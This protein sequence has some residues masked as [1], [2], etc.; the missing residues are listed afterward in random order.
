MSVLILKFIHVATISLWAVGLVALP[1]LYVQRRGLTGD[2]LH[3]L[4]SFTRFLYVAL[5]SPAA[6][7]AIGSGTAL[8]F[9]RETYASWFSLKLLLV[10]A[11]TVIHILSG[12]MILKLFEPG[13]TYPA[14]R[15]IAVTVLTL[16]LVSGILTLV[17]AKPN[18]DGMEAF[19]EM[20]TPGALPGL[21]PG[22]VQDL[23]SWAKL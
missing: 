3:T 19:A 21:L 8:I 12:L 17:L 9:L 18:L 14:W 15:F 16:L 10:A 13:G 7:A 5:I 20:F 2:R 4:H 22:F 1:L 23:I 11:M 6:F